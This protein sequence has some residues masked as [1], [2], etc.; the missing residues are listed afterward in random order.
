MK[1]LKIQTLVIVVLM[2]PSKNFGNFVK[3]ILALIPKYHFIPM[4]YSTIM[5]MYKNCWSQEEIVSNVK[6][7]LNGIKFSRL[8][9]SVSSV[10]NSTIYSMMGDGL[11]MSSRP[12]RNVCRSSWSTPYPG[13]CSGEF[14]LV[15]P[16]SSLSILPPLNSNIGKNLSYN[17][18]SM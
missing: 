7:E 12:K 14:S 4:T 15:N 13:L 16:I 1:R 6:R 11:C 2:A 10:G 18:K 5:Q 17:S 3:L 8:S 9:L